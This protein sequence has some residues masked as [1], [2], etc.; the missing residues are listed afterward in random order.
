MLLLL[1]VFV[2]FANFFHNGYAGVLLTVLQTDSLLL[3]VF[4]VLRVIPRHLLELFLE[5]FEHIGC[6]A[7]HH[8]GVAA[9]SSNL[10]ELL[11]TLFSLLH[12]HL[13]SLFEHCIM[14]F[15]HSSTG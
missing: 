5:L 11:L 12:F 10:L 8:E 13:L 3:L 7:V 4:L 15:K 14:S 2:A 1:L 9:F 6:L